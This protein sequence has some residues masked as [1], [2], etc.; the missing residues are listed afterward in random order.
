MVGVFA[1]P[2]ALLL[3]VSGGERDCAGAVVL[4]LACTCLLHLWLVPRLGLNGAAMGV[5]AGT[6]VWN[7]SLLWLAKCRL[8]FLPIGLLWPSLRHGKKKRPPPRLS[9]VQLR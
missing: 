7:G 4:S 6:V 3:S 9:C 2:T 8:G 1:G 5:L